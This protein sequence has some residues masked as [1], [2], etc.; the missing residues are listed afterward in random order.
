[1][2]SVHDYYNIIEPMYVTKVCNL[3]LTETENPG[4]PDFF[5]GLNGLLTRFLGLV[6]SKSSFTCP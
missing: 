6:F 5:P 2:R 4:N 1:M 3:G